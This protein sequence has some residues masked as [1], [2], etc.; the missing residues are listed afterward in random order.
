MQK[1]TAQDIG[2]NVQTVIISLISPNTVRQRGPIILLQAVINTVRYVV[3]LQ[4]I[5]RL[6]L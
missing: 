4:Q 6:I 5:L 1:K 3:T 2:I